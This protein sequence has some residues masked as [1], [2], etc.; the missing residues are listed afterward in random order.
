MIQNYIT[1]LYLVFLLQDV[2][3]NDLI[4]KT[5]INR[6]IIADETTIGMK[7]TEAMKNRILKISSMV[8]VEEYDLF[9]DINSQNKIDF[10]KFDYIIDAI[11]CVSS[12]ILLA[13]IAQELSI[14][15]ISSMGTGNKINPTMFEI[16]DIYKT[17]VCPLAR[18][19]RTE[20]KKRN[21]H[22]LKVVYSNEVPKKSNLFED[23][24]NVPLSCSFVP[25]VA[26]FIIASEV[27]KDLINN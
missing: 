19:M 3:K 4:H 17:S 5:N 15:I 10:K 2:S 1:I 16:D 11:D 22:K 21:V 14:K 26:G 12:K 7:K 24:K 23:N 25:S 18:V 27:I 9:F 20:L 13:Q 8:E 6:Q